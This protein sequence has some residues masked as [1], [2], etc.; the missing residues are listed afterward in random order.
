MEGLPERAGGRAAEGVPLACQPCQSWGAGGLKNEVVRDLGTGRPER[1]QMV[2]G[3]VATGDLGDGEERAPVVCEA[4]ESAGRHG[5]VAGSEGVEIVLGPTGEFTAKDV[6]GLRIV[7]VE[8]SGDL[9]GLDFEQ[10]NDCAVVIWP[11]SQA[12]HV[13]GRLGRNIFLAEKSESIGDGE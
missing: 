2:L 12:N 1:G 6:F 8:S 10:G 7:R 9:A 4:V 13:V 11:S 3:P 5:G